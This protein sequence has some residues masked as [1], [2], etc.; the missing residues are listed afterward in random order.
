MMYT[1]S[2]IHRLLLEWNI[3]IASERRLRKHTQ[4]VVTTNL[5]GEAVPLTKSGGEEIRAA[6]F[7]YIPE[8]KL[9]VSSY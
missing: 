3:S 9:K 6:P 7:V 1:N 2:I 4:S 8:L 5:K